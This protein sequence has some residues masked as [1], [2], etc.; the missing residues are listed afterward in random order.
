M[1]ILKIISNLYQRTTRQEE[2]EPEIGTNCNNRANNQSLLKEPKGQTLGDFP[3]IQ[4]MVQTLSELKQLLIKRGEATDLFVSLGSDGLI[5]ILGN[6]QQAVFGETAY[7]TIESKTAHL[8]YFIIKNPPFLDGN[9]RSGAWWFVDLLYR[10]QALFNAKG[11]A[12][13]N[14]T[15]LAALALLVPE[16]EPKQKDILIRLIMNMI[17]VEL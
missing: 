7:P 11:E 10:N 9:K 17:S 15:G 5:A 12:I 4:E 16:S 13:I 6:L 14:D 8:L 3:T 1:W 2:L